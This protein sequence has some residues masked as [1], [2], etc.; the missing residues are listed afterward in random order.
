MTSYDLVTWGAFHSTK[1][2]GLKFQVFCAANG[3]VFS[4]TRSQSISINYDGLK[5]NDVIVKIAGYA[6]TMRSRKILLSSDWERV[7][8]RQAK[9]C[10]ELVNIRCYQFK[11]Y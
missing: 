10:I 7:W 2:S 5:R 11:K 8:A 4:H 9:S 3:T 6:G 1:N